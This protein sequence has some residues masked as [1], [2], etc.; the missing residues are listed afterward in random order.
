MDLGRS[1]ERTTTLDR[2]V[3]TYVGTAL[4]QILSP[5]KK[6]PAAAEPA[7]PEPAEKPPPKKKGGIEIEEIPD[8]PDDLEEYN[9]GGDDD[10][11]DPFQNV[12]AIESCENLYFGDQEVRQCVYHGGEVQINAVVDLS[13]EE[14]E[15]LETWDEEGVEHVELGEDALNPAARLDEVVAFIAKNKDN[16]PVLIFDSKR[17]LRSAAMCAF[18]M[19]VA[20]EQSLTTAVQ[21]IEEDLDPIEHHIWR[22]KK[23][24][25]WLKQK[26][27]ELGLDDDDGQVFSSRENAIKAAEKFGPK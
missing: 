15:F 1:A 4:A 25:G 17:M 13:E 23:I 16:G 12:H 19:M 10:E 14:N 27:G 11:A 21:A 24:K 6:A 2:D 22:S 8:E 3:A 26:A 20:E 18:F 7:A 9:P 5:R